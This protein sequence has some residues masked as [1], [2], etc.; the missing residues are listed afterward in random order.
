LTEK[1]VHNLVSAEK[2]LLELAMKPVKGMES[3]KAGP[4]VRGRKVHVAGHKT[5][6]ERTPVAVSA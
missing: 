4:R 3:H 5:A 6:A 1:S 2:S